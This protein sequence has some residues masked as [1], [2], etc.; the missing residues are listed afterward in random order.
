MAGLC[1]KPDVDQT[2]VH[3][4][5]TVTNL[6]ADLRQGE[7]TSLFRALRFPRGGIVAVV[8]AAATPLNLSFQSGQPV[9]K[10]AGMRCQFFRLEIL[11]LFLFLLV[12][13]VLAQEQRVTLAPQMITASSEVA[14]FSGLADEQ[15]LIGDPPKNAATNGWRIPPQHWNHFP[16]HA[17]IDLGQ[18]RNLS[19]L[20]IFDTN[21]EGDF[22]VAT[23]EPGHWQMVTNY[24]GRQYLN[25]AR[26]PLEITTRYLR[27]ELKSPQA[28]FAEMALYEFTPEAHRAWLVRQ[29]AESKEHAARTA[30]MELA[31][32]E[33]ARRPVF[34]LP[35]FGRVQ[36]VD[37]VNCGAADPGHQFR[38]SPA[39]VSRVETILGQPCRVLPPS[40]G[41]ANYLAYR[42]GKWKL[43]KP[44]AAYVLAVEYPEDAPRSVIVMN[45]GNETSRGFHT[46]T[47]L[48]EALHPKY[49][50]NNPES[51]R[52]PLSGRYEKWTLYFN[53]HDRFP[54]L[55][56]I[57]GVKERR[58]TAADGFDVVIAQFSAENDPTSRGAAVSRIRL[59][60]VIDE[61]ALVQPPRRPPAPLP[62]R[63]IFW[64]E[65][66]ADGVIESDQEP[67]RG[68]KNRLD[69]YRYKANQMGFLGISSFSK[70]LLEFGACQHWDSSPHGGND[71]VH[72]AS[73]TKDLWGQIVAL[74]G[75]Q[76]FGVLPYY[77]YAGSKGDKGLGY[78]R[79]CQPLTRDDAYT[80]IA[81]IES[82][83]ADITDPDT[84]ADFKKML[85]LT[86]VRLRSQA[87][88]EGIWLRPRGQLPMSFA[89]AT[90]ERFARDANAGKRISRAE[91][92][93]DPALLKRY[94][95]WWFSQRR[96]FLIAMRDYLRE[97]G[98]AD[99]KVLFTAE[100]SEPGTSFPTW[101]QRVVTDDPEAWRGILA[102]PEHRRDYKTVVP[103][104]TGRVGQEGL[105]LEALQAA[106]LN[107]GNWEIP[108]ANPPADP[109]RYRDTPGVLMTHCFNR[110][111]TVESSNTFA[112]FR[113]PSGLALIRH[114][115]LNE[116]MLFDR[117][118]KEKL[119]YFVADI[120]RAGP[121]CM[122]AEALAVANG[123]PTMLGYL[124]G[125]NFGR[126]FPQYVS[127][128][129][130]NF[131]ALPALPSE[132]LSD[133]CAD[134]EVVVRAIRTPGHGTFLAVVNTGF[135]AKGRSLIRLPTAGRVTDA[136]SGKSLE[137]RAGTVEVA[138]HP[139]ELRSLRIEN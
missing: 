134:K 32:Q 59:Y 128:F 58:L 67:E 133:A 20:W 14:D 101:E 9:V 37:E 53:L 31:Q 139:F 97:Q 125:G 115:S 44:G 38:E 26:L 68:V 57:R 102:A 29:A 40:A 104:S 126:G 42:I 33:V 111:Y 64:R 12:V 74:M 5:L 79:R 105:Y 118:D 56:F 48:G 63:H 109:S 88:F 75:R 6:A 108:H 1:R 85:D 22:E 119:G 49:V 89:D 84:R 120:E 117:Q 34:D 130:A 100:A 99:A 76:G 25:W 103:I 110:A 138:L 123:D 132:R 92:R 8:G 113:G 51:L 43:L 122:M 86:V 131:L 93:S 7:A 15:D 46:G 91:L 114:Y 2:V 78:Q 96:E 98:I 47:T 30:A 72:F 65:E 41:E 82:A 35:P 24:D 116:N 60:E 28:N 45:G 107:W 13:E 127:E 17:T 66:M 94:E 106:P 21:G 137:A 70:D 23:G 55:A 54:D 39:G 61:A 69:Y 27:L 16:Y 4:A 90:R 62:R 135:N 71:W 11:S 52:A 136:V 50:N 36:L 80:P 73:S 87:H 83:N 77:E 112:A 19:A 95:D 129:N 3:T 10:M 18:P 124:H 81:W 121:A